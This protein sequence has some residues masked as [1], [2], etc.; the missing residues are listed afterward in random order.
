VTFG[1][2]ARLKLLNKR[3]MVPYIR[4]SRPYVSSGTVQEECSSVRNA[5]REK[6]VDAAREGW[7]NR[8][9]D[10]SRRNN[11]LF[12]K[13]I[14]S[15]TLELPVGDQLTGHTEENLKLKRPICLRCKVQKPD[16]SPDRTN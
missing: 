2:S 7:I 9:I 6:L 4:I 13:P 12:Y 10:L 5:F 8:L 3:R 14:L 15:G 11:L 1:I 16:A